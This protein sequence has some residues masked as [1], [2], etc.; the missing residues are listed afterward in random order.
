MM[1]PSTDELYLRWLYEKISPAS[2][3]NPARTYWRFARQLYKKEFLWFVPNDDN[4][5]AD[6]ISLRDEFV[7]DWDVHPTIDWM[8]EN[9]S[10][11]ELLIG[12]S[13]R[14][15]F[16]HEGEPR[17]RFWEMIE[18]MGIEKCDDR[19]YRE[20][21]ELVHY[22]DEALDTVI[23]RTYRRDGHEGGLFPLTDPRM[24]QRKIEIWYQMAAYVIEKEGL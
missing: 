23:W 8:R 24:D 16:M 12:L 5:A 3:R 21:E 2:L 13:R 1:E 20:R 11:L 18:N 9:C 19:Q 4:R 14:F 7:D 17:D 6:G 15:A 22:V 10:M